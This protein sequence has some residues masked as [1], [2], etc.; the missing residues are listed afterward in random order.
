VGVGG[1]A[2]HHFG[3]LNHRRR[4][5]INFVGHGIQKISYLPSISTKITRLRGWEL[6]GF[7]NHLSPPNSNQPR[8]PPQDVVIITPY[9]V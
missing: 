2:M 4:F 6:T 9:G 7:A 1:L 3:L 8:C 5:K